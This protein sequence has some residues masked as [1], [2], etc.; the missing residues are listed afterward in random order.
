MEKKFDV[1]EALFEAL[2]RAISLEIEQLEG[3]K[4]WA[5]QLHEYLNRTEHFQQSLDWLEDDLS[6]KVFLWC[7]QYRT[8]AYL[9]QSNLV[10]GHLY[11]PVIT[12][13][14]WRSMMAEAKE[15]PESDLEGHL[16]IDLIENFVMD[17]Y[18]L[19][20]ICEVST[21]D[22]VIDLGAFNGNSSIVLARHAGHTGRVF[23]FE[24]NPGTRD[25]LSRNLIKA[26]VSN[27][28]VVGAGVSDTPGALGFVRDGAASR[29]DPHGDITVPVVTIDSF[30]AD[31][32]VKRL[33]FLK[34]DIEGFEMP[35]LR[36]AAH[37]IREYRPKLAIAVY[38]LHRDMYEIQAFIR[39]VSPWYKFYLRHN[40]TTDAEIVL[41]CEPIGRA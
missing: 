13:S 1:K 23:A 18:R 16:D 5:L 25:M 3:P 31:N 17:G 39:D 40:Y 10:A 12:P 9:H 15:L 11:P 2:K 20:D 41:F 7:V 36:G 4:T 14:Q 33:D 22:V 35:A 30:V 26:G 34:L 19:P 38:H 29:F 27:V 21:G 24:P 37:T 32:D 28:E 6:R 8:T